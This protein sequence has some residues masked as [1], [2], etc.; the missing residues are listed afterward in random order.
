MEKEKRRILITVAYDGTEY[1]GWQFQPNCITVEGCLNECLTELLK[2][3]IKVIGASRTD[4]QV[5]AL[6]NLA[7]FDT[8]ARIPAEKIPYAMNQTL[9]DS[10]RIQKGEEVALDF[11][12]RKCD[13]RKTYEYRILV[14]KFQIPQ[15]RNYCHWTYHKLEI[16]QMQAAANV[17]IGE[18]D[19][20]SFCSVHAQSETRIRTIYDISVQEEMP[21]EICILVTGNGFLYNMVRIIAG[22]L[23]EAGRG[24]ITPEDMKRILE[25][26]NRELAGPTA[27]PQGLTLLKYEFD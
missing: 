9:P 3:E 27:P 10:I 21:G 23:M 19:F 5:H 7:V 13:T 12:P 16:D 20:T 1:H 18:H 6:G 22:T 25:G 11:H 15:K 14:S 8:T 17:L 2:E 4:A 26:K 24:R